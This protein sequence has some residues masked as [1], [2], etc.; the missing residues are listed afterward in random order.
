MPGDSFPFGDYDDDPRLH[1]GPRRRAGW[2][3]AFKRRA[4]CPPI[5]FLTGAGNEVIAVRAMKYGA[6]DYLRKQS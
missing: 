2:L 1:A 3:R 5:I 4:D 6:D